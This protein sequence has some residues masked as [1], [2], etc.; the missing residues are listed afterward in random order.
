[1]SEELCPKSER[2]QA[3]ARTPRPRSPNDNYE[4]VEVGPTNTM[5]TAA[6]PTVAENVWSMA[7][8]SGIEQ[9]SATSTT[10]TVV[11]IRFF[12]GFCRKAMIYIGTKMNSAPPM[13]T[14]NLARRSAAFELGK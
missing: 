14:M 4:G 3:L 1:M 6:Y 10:A 7:N 11:V 2:K 13:A 8:F 5:S 9:I 12:T